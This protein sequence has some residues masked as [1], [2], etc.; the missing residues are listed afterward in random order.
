[1]LPVA[2]NSVNIG[3]RNKPNVGLFYCRDRVVGVFVQGPAW[4]FKGWPW[5]GNPV[6]IFSKSKWLIRWLFSS[7]N[8]I[9][10]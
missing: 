3:N 6:E 4:Q 7:V 10:C 9:T 2:S 1:M 8:T 5:S